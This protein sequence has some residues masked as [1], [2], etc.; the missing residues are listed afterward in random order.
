MPLKYL[1]N[2]LR[3]HEM[4]LINCKWQ[5]N[6]S[7]YCVL[8]VASNE[9]DINNNDSDDNNTIFTIKDTTLYVPVVTLSTRD[10]QKLW[11]L[12][13]KGFERWDKGQSDNKNAANELRYFLKSNFVGVTTLF[14]LVYPNRNNDSKIFFA[15]KYYLPKGII[16][17]HSATIN[18]KIF[19]CQAVGWDIND[20]RKSEN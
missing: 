8:S 19:Y 3:S 17:G 2:L 16:K 20:M 5:S 14:V 1:S 10:N 12:V 6:W 18:G 4:P 15:R 11:K 9:N 13:S 7:K